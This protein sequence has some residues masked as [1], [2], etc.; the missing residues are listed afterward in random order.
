[1]RS[2]IV[3]AALIVS[4]WGCVGPDLVGVSPYVTELDEA[5]RAIDHGRLPPGRRLPVAEWRTTLTRVENRVASAAVETCHLT[6][7]LNCDRARQR[8]AIVRD[9]TINAW[10]DQ[11]LRI[12]VHS[13]LLANAGTDEEIAA[14]LAH[15][16]GHIF[17]GHFEQKARN[18][19][20]GALI[21][22]IAGALLVGTG[23]GDVRSGLS[24]TNGDNEH[25]RSRV[26][27]T[28]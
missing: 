11:E 5:R 24:I 10:V 9:D 3:S 25:R 15:E 12:G 22:M 16:Y 27:P 28:V 17:A 23:Y 8:A 6:Q 1:M 2:T 13:G 20:T 4:C 21:G 18:A 26:Q 19:G 7:A 14:V